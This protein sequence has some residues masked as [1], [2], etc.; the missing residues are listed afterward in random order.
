[1]SNIRPHTVEICVRL[2]CVS[3]ARV[4]GVSCGARGRSA[5]ASPL[6]TLAQV[7]ICAPRS[8]PPHR[9]PCV[10]RAPCFALRARA[11]AP[12]YA[13]RARV[14]A[15][16]YA[17]RAKALSFGSVATISALHARSY[18][19]RAT[20]SARSRR[21]EFVPLTVRYALTR[22]RLLRLWA[23]FALSAYLRATHERCT[24]HTPVK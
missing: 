21:A 5:R 20:H 23:F 12:C 3:G 8:C 24:A 13:L 10:V 22:I 4:V 1:M 15:P 9:T 16:C 18:A 6:S 17:L 14:R 7:S 19:L 11:R 2:R